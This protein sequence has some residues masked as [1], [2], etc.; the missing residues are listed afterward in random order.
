MAES[1]ILEYRTQLDMA[2]EETREIKAAVFLIN[3]DS[4]EA[5]RR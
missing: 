4:I 1:L 3:M 2:K 5:H